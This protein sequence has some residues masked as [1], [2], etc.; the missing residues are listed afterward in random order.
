MENYCAFSQNHKCIHWTDY[1][2][3]RFELEEASTLCH[4]NWNEIQ[5]K[6]SYIQLLQN[7]LRE[8]NISFPTE[9]E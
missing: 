3:T 5:R 2:V 6:E 4:E 8:N 9:F 1:E 7:L